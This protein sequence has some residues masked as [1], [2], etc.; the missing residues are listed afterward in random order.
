MQRDHGDRHDREHA[1]LKYL[2]HEWGIERFRA[3]V[4]QRLGR[5]LPAP[6]PVVFDAADD[7][8]GWHPQ[9]DGRWFLGVKVENGRIADRGAVRVRSGLRAVVER[10]SP[11]VRLTPREDILLTDLADRDRPNVE[12]LLRDHGVLAAEQW[13]PIKRNSFACPALPTCGLALTESE[14]ALP[15][16][17]DELEAELD[18]L[19]LGG[20]DAHVRMT[21]CPNRP[22]LNGRS[23]GIRPSGLRR[24]GC[25]GEE[26][27]SNARVTSGVGGVAS[28]C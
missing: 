26:E 11:G 2:I 1:R 23:P 6:E 9:G 19:G 21:G 8:L 3:E 17:L 27:S 5:S 13:V 10:F 20:L 22:G 7:H 18:A 16:V 28:D 14:R 12:A 24:R 4:A 25:H 15:G